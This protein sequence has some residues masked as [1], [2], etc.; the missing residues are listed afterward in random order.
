MSKTIV[1]VIF[2]VVTCFT[3]AFWLIASGIEDKPVLPRGVPRNTT[4]EELDEM[5]EQWSEEV[6]PSPTEGC[7]VEV[8]E[9]NVD[10]GIM[11]PQAPLFHTFQIR[12]NGFNPLT[13]GDPQA[14][15]DGVSAAFSQ[16][17][18]PAGG[19]AQFKVRCVPF[20]ESGTYAT[21]V[22]LP[23]SD[24]SR[25]LIRFNFRGLVQRRLE[26]APRSIVFPDLDPHDQPQPR[27]TVIFSKVW[28][29]FEI[30]DSSCD[31]DGLRWRIEPADQQQLAEHDAKSGYR[32]VAT[33]PSN[34]PSGKYRALLRLRIQPPSE[35]AEPLNTQL[36]IAGKVLR[37]LC[38][39]GEE[40]DRHGL[41]D[42]GHIRCG[43]ERRVVLRVA[44]RDPELAQLPDVNI[45]VEPS[46]VQARLLPHDDGRGLP[47]SYLLEIVV[48]D[49]APVCSH[50]RPADHGQIRIRTGHPRIPEQ[51]LQ[52]RM[53]V[54]PGPSAGL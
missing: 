17:T 16:R 52:L 45:D 40:I 41:I 46:F 39:Y 18:I 36:H 21:S 14:D 47:G 1:V 38:I 9:T 43:T 34:L 28:D 13:L 5:I 15:D 20:I 19:E 8:D 3:A 42:L 29:S 44:V 2:A 31:L 25:P 53:A 27:E 22:K 37:R 33:L 26:A 32:V 49:T 35:E 30:V 24:P 11:D 12:N 6:R 54:P 51:R 23:T 4:K 48:P 7:Q 50:L 10:F